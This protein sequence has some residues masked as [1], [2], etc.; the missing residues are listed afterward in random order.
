LWTVGL[1]YETNPVFVEQR[2]SRPIAPP[3]G[4][5]LK[6]QLGLKLE[7]ARG[8]VKVIVIDS[9]QQPTEN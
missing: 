7:S 2:S 9:V 8:H 4:D 3:I 6:E 5:A 1:A